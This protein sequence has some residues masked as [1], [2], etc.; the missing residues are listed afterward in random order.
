VDLTRYI[1]DRRWVVLLGPRR[2]GKTSLARCATAELG[3]QCTVVDAREDSNLAHA[4]VSSLATK[5]GG[6][7]T[8]ARAGLQ[9]PH[10]PFSLDVTYSKSAI[11]KTLDRLLEQRSKRTVLLLDEAQWF[12]NPRGVVMLLAHIYDYHYEKVTCLITGSAVGVMGSITEPDARSALFGR[13][14][15]TMEVERWS[16]S[17]SLGFLKEGCREKKLPYSDGPMSRVVDEI[18]GIPGWLTLFGYHYASL[19]TVDVEGALRKTKEE[20]MKIIR[21]ELASISRIAVGRE[22]QIGILRE[23][24]AGNRRFGELVEA[25]GL[26]HQVLL[27]HL[28]MLQRLR[29]VEKDRDERYTIIDPMLKDF[30]SKGNL[31]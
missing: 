1:E 11:A 29:Y 13:A 8:S 27:R 30:L 3:Y 25:A 24:S 20:G 10:T 6:K 18:G 17:V 5:G 16:P 7:D 31:T 19:Q 4:L 23:L 2:I 15:T 14:I 26:P 12:R 21:E 22:R 28:A 9:I